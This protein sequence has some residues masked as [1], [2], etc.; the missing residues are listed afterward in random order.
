MGHNH[1]SSGNNF[2]SSYQSPYDRQA[3]AGVNNGST[4]M[5]SGNVSGL[6]GNPTP[7]S[8]QR[9]RERVAAATASGAEQQ[10]MPGAPPLNRL[11]D[12]LGNSSS[13]PSNSGGGSNP[14]TPG[15]GACL[16]TPKTNL[17]SRLSP[18]SPTQVDP[19]YTYG[20]SIQPDDQLDE[21]WITIFGFPP[22]ATSHILQEFAN[23]G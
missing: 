14:F 8:L 20:E 17:R 5:L 10:Q 18:A 11:A 4:T 1:H 22:S 15:S 3:G 16:T 23:Y 12:T 6:Y 9:E 21:T 7:S 13:Q 2:G 19:H